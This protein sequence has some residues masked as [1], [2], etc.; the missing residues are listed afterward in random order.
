MKLYDKR[1]ILKN[2]E[3]AVPEELCVYIIS[4]ERP[5]TDC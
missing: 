4:S 3:M 5:L 2:R 1:R